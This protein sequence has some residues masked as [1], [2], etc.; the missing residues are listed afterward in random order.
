[1][2]RALLFLLLAGAACAQSIDQVNSC[3]VNVTQGANA[4]GVHLSLA[5]SAVGAIAPPYNLSIYT[6]STQASDLPSYAWQPAS[7]GLQSGQVT[8]FWQSLVANSSVQLGSV[9]PDGS[10]VTNV[11]VQGTQ[12]KL[13]QLQEDAG[14]GA[15]AAAQPVSIQGGKLTGVDGQPLKLRGINYFGFENLGGTGMVDGLWAG[16]D[17]T[18]LDFATVAY[19]MQLLG[20]NAVSQLTF[21]F[22]SLTFEFES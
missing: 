8:G 20:F 18:S 3:L 15:E 22:Q 9:L 16:S 17:S 5:T 11:T 13:Q 12:C 21:D 7:G 1:M 2:M 4:N 14:A 6:T 19:R 10:G